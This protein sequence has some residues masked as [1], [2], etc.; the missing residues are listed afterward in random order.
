MPQGRATATQVRSQ[1]WLLVAL[2]LLAFAVLGGPLLASGRLVGDR[3]ADYAFFRDT[4]HSLNVYGEF[5]WWNPSFQAGFPFYYVQFLFW[6]G[7]EPVFAALATV[8][9]AL[10]RAGFTIQSYF[11]LYVV[12]FALLAPLLLSVSLLV[13]ARQILRHPL[14]ILLVIVLAAFSPGV[15][16]N[17][18]DLGGEPTAYGFLFAAAWIAFLRTPD[19]S[20]FL[21]LCLAA[22][23]VAVSLTYFG[24]FWNIF[25]VPAFVMLVSIGPPARRV[26][27]ACRQIPARWWAAATGGVVLCVL[28]TAIT[29]L[30]GGD[31]LAAPAQG[32]RYHAYERLRPG[33][34]MEALA[35]STPGVGF[36]W[37]DYEDPDASYVPR[38]V[39]ITSGYSS[40]GYMG[41][42]TL[43]LVGVG[44]VVG[45]P[46]WSV[47]LCGCIAAVM[48]IMMLSAYSPVF[49]L[50][51][52]W[53]SPLRA[54][55]HYSDFVMRVG[56][57]G[58]FILAA[59]L[60]L[61]ALLRPATARRWMLLALFAVTSA[62]SVLWLMRL[63]DPAATGTYLFGLALAFILLYGVGL[64]QFARAATARDRRYAVMAL[65]ALLV[66][67]TSTLAFAHLRLV[68]RQGVPPFDEPGPDRLGS[69]AGKAEEGFLYLRGMDDPGLLED[70]ERPV[71]L[72]ALDT[73]EPLGDQQ[74][75]V[76]RRT[77]NSIAMDVR[78]PEQA[79]LEWRDAFFSFWRAS[80]DGA[81]VPVV[82]T[83]DNMKAVLVPAGASQVVF[84]FSPDAVRIAVVG[85]YLAMAIVVGG[86]F[87]ARKR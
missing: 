72:L 14:A 28:P 48:T 16:F 30:Y 18:G 1:V 78:V 10:G 4:L 20:R 22:M 58:V 52:G 69:V 31:I 12:Y 45:R 65:L 50:L 26:A 39:W 71:R 67:D 5:P 24:L 36:E 60:G 3:H 56:L 77:Y 9:W 2:Q 51:L 29:Y 34:P 41:L 15:V 44:L 79:R 54:V 64:A 61:E 82:R 43:P 53:P 13:L 27:Q 25:F 33:N 80:V 66:L 42:L 38:L 63:Q 70:A 85:S 17:V 35:I 47:R 84:R 19:R 83:S 57:F 40:Y 62:A 59:G 75:D 76:V 6:P 32:Q 21:L 37:T 49:S 73:G 8:V 7:R 74:V 11:A 55:N 68:Y 87:R 23:T 86:W 46:Y 81:E